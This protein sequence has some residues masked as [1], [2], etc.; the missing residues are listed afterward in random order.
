[1][2]NNELHYKGSK[3]DTIK[4][5]DGGSSANQASGNINSEAV[6]LPADLAAHLGY[7]EPNALS[8][9]HGDDDNYGEEEAHLPAMQA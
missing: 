1:M 3:A 8:S 9:H 5:E 6:H 2:S 7:Y 4:M